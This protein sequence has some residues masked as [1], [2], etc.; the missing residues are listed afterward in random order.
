MIF[1]AVFTKL[2]M[3]NPS[4]VQNILKTDSKEKYV[5]KIRKNLKSNINI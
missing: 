2:F 3:V 4:K 1:W 5:M